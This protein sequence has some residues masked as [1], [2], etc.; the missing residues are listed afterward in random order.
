L[1]TGSEL[2]QGAMRIAR[3]FAL[4]LEYTRLLVA[5]IAERGDERWPRKVL[6][7][8]LGAGSIAKHIHRERPKA[9]QVVVE[10]SA[11]VI[12]A[13][14]Q[15]FRLP[16]EGPRLRIVHGDGLAFVTGGEGRYDLIIVDAFDAEGRAGPLESLPFYLAARAMLAPAGVLAVNL[17]HHRRDPTAALRRLREAFDGQVEERLAKSGNRVAIAR[18][19]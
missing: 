18:N 19:G 7:V 6:Q 15:H 1:H 5:P 12:V 8:G 2:V 11:E 10:L 16:E 9:K 14:R 4:E 3:P 17:L 13:A